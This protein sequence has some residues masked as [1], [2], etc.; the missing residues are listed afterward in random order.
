MQDHPIKSDIQQE[1][2]G[3]LEL[4]AGLSLQGKKGGMQIFGWLRGKRNP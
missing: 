4:G 2:Q 1:R 3:I